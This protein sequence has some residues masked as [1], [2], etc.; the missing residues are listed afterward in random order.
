[1][2]PNGKVDRRNL[3]PPTSLLNSDQY[4]PPATTT[5]KALALIWA[6]VL[7]LP[8]DKIGRDDNFFD[9][10]GH[11]LSAMRLLATLKNDFL[12]ACSLK[13]FFDLSDLKQFSQSVDDRIELVLSLIADI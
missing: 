7:N 12:Y 9:L 13:D 2:L 5:E 3:P 8:V 10:G 6:R 1:R 11:S 4:V